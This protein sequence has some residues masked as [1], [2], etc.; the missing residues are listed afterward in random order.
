MDRV[1]QLRSQ[2]VDYQKKYF[3]KGL[4]NR[5][6]SNAFSQGEIGSLIL[7]H[8]IASILYP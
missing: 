3:R 1:Y 8:T 5:E 6:N 7:P 4:S 2:A